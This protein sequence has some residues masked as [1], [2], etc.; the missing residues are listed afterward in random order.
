MDLRS[1]LIG[2]DALG[3]QRSDVLLDERFILR[4]GHPAPQ[5]LAHH[6]LAPSFSLMQV[7]IYYKGDEVL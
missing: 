2:I 3:D 5:V 6:H 1:Q 4:M 7:G